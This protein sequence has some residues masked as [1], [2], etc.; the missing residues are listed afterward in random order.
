MI[1]FPK[2]LP[3][4]PEEATKRIRKIE[5]RVGSRGLHE[6]L[7]R[8]LLRPPRP[9]SLISFLKF[10]FFP[11][12]C[13]LN[14]PARDGSFDDGVSKDPDGVIGRRVCELFRILTVEFPDSYASCHSETGA[15]ERCTEISDPRTIERAIGVN[16]ILSRVSLS[17]LRLL[18]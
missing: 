1:P 5:F 16:S 11:S 6:S 9:S 4:S 15:S 2:G 8:G 14:F 18:F 13:T 10:R 17:L 3:Y 12:P 7:L